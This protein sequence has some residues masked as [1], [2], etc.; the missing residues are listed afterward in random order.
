MRGT[1][2]TGSIYII[3]TYLNR[4][5]T[6]VFIPF[7]EYT[8]VAQCGRINALKPPD[9]HKVLSV[10]VGGYFLYG[11]RNMEVQRIGWG[12]IEFFFADKHVFK[13]DICAWFI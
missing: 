9:S 1:V 10:S 4:F 5:I 7:Q 6:F 12:R 8:A 2:N 13:R 11:I 3:R